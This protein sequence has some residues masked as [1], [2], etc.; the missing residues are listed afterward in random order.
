MVV[1]KLALSLLNVPIVIL[2]VGVDLP[3]CTL[4]RRIKI[5]F[6]VVVT[7]LGKTTLC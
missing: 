7:P 3:N 4:N 6:Y 5:V 1:V 2:N